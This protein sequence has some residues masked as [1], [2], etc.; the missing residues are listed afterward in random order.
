MA[1]AVRWWAGQAAPCFQIGKNSWVRRRKWE[2]VPWA[3][4]PERTSLHHAVLPPLALPPTEPVSQLAAAAS[5][6]SAAGGR[7]VCTLVIEVTQAR[8]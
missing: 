5:A 6:E 7:R 8:G 4:A 3:A 2:V 1:P